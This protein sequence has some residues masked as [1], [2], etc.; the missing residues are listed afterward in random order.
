L[1]SIAEVNREILI[2]DGRRLIRTESDR[3]SALVHAIDDLLF[4]LEELNLKGVDRVP[5]PLRTRAG[6]LIEVVHPRLQA[7]GDAPDPVRVRH[8]VVPM[9]DVLFEVQDRIL[10]LLHPDRIGDRDDAPALS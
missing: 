3:L 4:S 5:A 7:P 10:H 2:A 1:A 8:R 6:K 9:M